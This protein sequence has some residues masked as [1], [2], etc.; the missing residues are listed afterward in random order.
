[1]AIFAI[2]LILPKCC[3]NP[4]TTR[5]IPCL[6]VF[7]TCFCTFETLTLSLLSLC[8][9]KKKQDNLSL[10][11]M[12]LFHCCR[13]SS[14]CVHLWVISSWSMYLL[15]FIAQKTISYMNLNFLLLQSKRTCYVHFHTTCLFIHSIY[16]SLQPYVIADSHSFLTT[17]LSSAENF[18][19]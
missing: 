6:A 18:S 16:L 12:Y 2:K 5:T 15:K 13:G 8:F 4:F 10:W 19:N 7:A 17:Q 1:M 9:C 11:I 3:S 14:S